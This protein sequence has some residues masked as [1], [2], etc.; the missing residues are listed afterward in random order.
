MGNEADADDVPQE[1]FL[2]GFHKL[3]SFQSRA[4][5]GT[6]VYRIAVR[7]A[8]DNLHSRYSEHER[9]A[10]EASD[11]ETEFGHVSDHT[12]GPEQLVLSGESHVDIQF[13]RRQIELK[14][15]D[16]KRERLWRSTPLRLPRRSMSQMPTNWA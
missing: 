11:G 4:N 3:A 6:W 2:R 10:L 12:P 13:R 9:Q 5:S 7:C 8:L 1:T 15:F 14:R 16:V